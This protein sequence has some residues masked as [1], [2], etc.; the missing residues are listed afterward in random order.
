MA[1]PHAKHSAAKVAK[2]R[3]KDL[4]ASLPMPSLA[5]SS[6]LST[7]LAAGNSGPSLDA[8]PPASGGA[9]FLKGG[10]ASGV[11]RLER[12]HRGK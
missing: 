2:R 5:R 3:A 10:A 8:I 7:A 4:T 11:G 9:G 6:G 1:H 12:Q